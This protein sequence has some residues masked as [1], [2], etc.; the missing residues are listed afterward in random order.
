MP[1]SEWRQRVRVVE[2]MKRLDAGIKVESIGLD[3]GYASASA[4][5]A[6]F[7]KR[8]GMTP[9]EYRRGQRSEG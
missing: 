4:F 1:L 8:T 6:M 9:D 7:K 2:A 3:L 5:I